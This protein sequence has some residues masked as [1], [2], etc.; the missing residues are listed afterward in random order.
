MSTWICVGN[1]GGGCSDLLTYPIRWPHAILRDVRIAGWRLTSFPNSGLGTPVRETP[2]LVR[3]S[4]RMIACERVSAETEGP[5]CWC[6]NPR[7]E[8][9][10]SLSKTSDACDRT[11]PDGRGS[12]EAAETD[13]TNANMPL[14]AGLIGVPLGKRTGL[15][16]GTVGGGV[17]GEPRVVDVDGGD[18]HRLVPTRQRHRAVRR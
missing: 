10:D 16:A 2:F 13:Q 5:P 8:F 11:L 1:R 17:D 18:A 3:S 15:E 6:R 9:S 7:V 14:R 4:V 12:E